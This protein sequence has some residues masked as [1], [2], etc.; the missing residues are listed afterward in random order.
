M[1]CYWIC[2]NS[3]IINIQFLYFLMYIFK[4]IKGRINTLEY[5]KN[6]CCKYFRTEV[7]PNID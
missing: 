6:N 1:G 2:L 5:V 4:D 3:R 7:V